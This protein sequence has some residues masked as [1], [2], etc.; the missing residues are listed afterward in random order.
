MEGKGDIFDQYEHASKANVGF[1]EKFMRGD[2]VK[3]GWINETDIERK[4]LP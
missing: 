4:P 3:A 2:K 1:Y